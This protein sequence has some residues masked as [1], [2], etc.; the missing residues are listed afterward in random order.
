MSGDTAASA[1]GAWIVYGMDWND[2]PVGLHATEL[3]ALRQ[4]A[5]DGCG[6]HVAFWPF[7][8]EWGDVERYGNRKPRAKA[9]A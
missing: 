9:Q 8:V 3:E 1:P 4:A 5:A 6:H 7:G 2:Y